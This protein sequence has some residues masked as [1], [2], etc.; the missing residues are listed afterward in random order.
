MSTLQVRNVPEEVS[1]V[2]KARAASAGQSLSQYVLNEL[3]RI[4]ERPTLDELSA[5]I[6]ARGHVNPDRSAADVLADARAGR[7]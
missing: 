5:R 1:R 7:P 6:D 3:E 4:A 2:L